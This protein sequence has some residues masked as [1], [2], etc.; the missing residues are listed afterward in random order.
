[1]FGT[2]E[3]L[4][5]DVDPIND[6]CRRLEVFYTNGSYFHPSN[7]DWISDDYYRAIDLTTQP[8]QLTEEETGK[9]NR[10]ITRLSEKYE[11]IQSYLGES[12]LIDAFN[13]VAEQINNINSVD[14]NR[15]NISRTEAATS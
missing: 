14:P 7:G 2:H 4:A 11:L 3:V 1:M 6:V 12:S 13:S 15:S 10:S 5:R 8:G 9:L